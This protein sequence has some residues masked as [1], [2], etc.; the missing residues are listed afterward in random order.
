MI[1]SI[2]LRN[3]LSHE[4]TS[5]SLED[6]I[7]VFVGAN[8]AGKSSVIDAVTYALYGEHTR[9]SDRNLIRRGASWGAVVMTFTYGQARY[10]VE[11]KLGADGRL[12]GVTLRQIY[13]VQ[14]LLATGERKQYGESVSGMISSL[15]RLDYEKM[16]VAAIIQQGELDRII[17]YRPAQFK[18]LMDSLIGIDRFGN[19]YEAMR[20]PVD[21][22]RER[23][24]R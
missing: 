15:M 1:E 19:A 5:I 14:R 24:R 20:D 9:D 7:N 17:Q 21:Q 3:F 6:G 11:R 8:G 23:L 22:F 13:P 16:R 4:E 18:A 2:L 12:E 10:T